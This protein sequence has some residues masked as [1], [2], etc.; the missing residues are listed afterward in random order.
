MESVI[1]YTTELYNV[2]YPIK[3]YVTELYNV[4][5]EFTKINLSL[6]R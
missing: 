1:S 4:L 3:T 6:S 2:Y 5:P